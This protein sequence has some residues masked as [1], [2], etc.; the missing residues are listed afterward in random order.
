MA[1]YCYYILLSCLFMAPHC[2]RHA[3][4]LLSSRGAR[5]AE[6]GK[7]VNSPHGRRSHQV[8]TAGTVNIF[9]S[10]VKLGTILDI[11]AA[12]IIYGVRVRRGRAGDVISADQNRCA[13]RVAGHRGPREA[14][15]TAGLRHP[16][17]RGKSSRHDL[18]EPGADHVRPGVV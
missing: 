15:R 6:V 4:P 1:T 12:T 17:D 11:S 10:N 9:L 16:G 13:D 18:P 3:P 5:V 2:R 8:T 7:S 14:G